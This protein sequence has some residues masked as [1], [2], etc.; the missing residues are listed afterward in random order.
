MLGGKTLAESPLTEPLLFDPGTYTLSFAAVGFQPKDVEFKIEAGSESERK[1][2][3]EPV[4][5]VVKPVE[6]DEP[7]QGAEGPHEPSPLPIYIGGGATGG[8]LIFATIYG[9]S[10]ISEHHTYT[11][12]ATTKL[13]RA[14]AKDNGR[15]FAHVTDACL[16]G[17]IAAGAFT[18]YWYVYRWAPEMKAQGKDH[19]LLIGPWA[20]TGAAGAF[21]QGSF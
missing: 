17:M 8:F 12:P 14:D 2:A 19:W 20:S 21:A 5:V 6:T 7:S 18:A 11:N 4:K 1:I 9:I 10:A 16:V 3:L 15:T 13:D